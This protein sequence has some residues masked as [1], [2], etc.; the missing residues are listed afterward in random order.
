MGASGNIT[1]YNAKGAELIEKDGKW[2]I[3]KIKTNLGK[4]VESNQKSLMKAIFEEGQELGT[5]Q[6]SP[7]NLFSAFCSQEMVNSKSDFFSSE[8]SAVR[9]KQSEWFAEG[10]ILGEEVILQVM[11]KAKLG[12]QS[13]PTTTL[14]KDFWEKWTGFLNALPKNQRTVIVLLNGMG[15]VNFF[16]GAAVALGLLTGRDLFRLYNPEPDQPDD[17]KGYKAIPN[18]M[19]IIDKYLSLTESDR[20]K[21]RDK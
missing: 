8:V 10:N 14:P 9:G 19:D 11:E 18:E 3:T 13:F 1:S 4:D 20:L 2:L 15:H 17:W 7:F 21:E 12:V 5:Y 6:W 16:Y